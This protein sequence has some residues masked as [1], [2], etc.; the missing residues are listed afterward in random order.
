MELQAPLNGGSKFKW[1]QRLSTGATRAGNQRRRLALGSTTAAR[2]GAR[3]DP[4]SAR[5]AYRLS[6]STCSRPRA[7]SR[8]RPRLLSDGR[9]ACLRADGGPGRRARR[10]RH[11]LAVARAGRPRK[12]P[13]AWNRT[14]CGPTTRATGRSAPAPPGPVRW[15]CGP[16]ENSAWRPWPSPPCRRRAPAGNRPPASWQ[17]RRLRPAGLRRR[18]VRHRAGRAHR[19]T[20]LAGTAARNPPRGAAGSTRAAA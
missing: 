1:T 11:G 3:R 20:G 7:A 10:R 9:A 15:C 5:T 6:T 13:A 18:P 14:G 17:A 4:R 2:N 8:F 19:R 12:P 16:V